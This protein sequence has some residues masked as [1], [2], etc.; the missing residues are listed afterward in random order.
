MILAAF[1][2]SMDARAKAFVGQNVASWE[3]LAVK[4]ENACRDRPQRLEHSIG[5]AACGYETASGRPKWPSRDPIGERGALNLLGFVNNRPIDIF[6]FLGLA[7]LGFG[8][9]KI[10]ENSDPEWINKTSRGAW[11]PGVR[12]GQAYTDCYYKLSISCSACEDDPNCGY[13]TGSASVD[14][15]TRIW[16]Q[17]ELYPGIPEPTFLIPPETLKILVGHEQKRVEDCHS[18]AA[19]WNSIINAHKICTL[20]CESIKTA[21]EEAFD[22]AKL[23]AA[24]PELDDPA[25]WVGIGY[26]DFRNQVRMDRLNE[27]ERVKSSKK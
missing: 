6:D 19:R 14:P 21:L 9:L 25:D 8:D 10:I 27:R 17:E 12:I 11:V 15:K 22:A 26:D 5:T 23:E 7:E 1:G 18:F 13:I 20:H 3:I 2:G 24:D 4:D 16:M